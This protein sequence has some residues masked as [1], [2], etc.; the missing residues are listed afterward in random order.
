MEHRSKP[1]Y[2]CIKDCHFLDKTSFLTFRYL[3]RNIN[4][5]WNTCGAETAVF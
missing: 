2:D 4:R 1:R 5:I 3:R